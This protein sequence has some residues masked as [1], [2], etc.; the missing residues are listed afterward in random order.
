MVVKTTSPHARFDTG[1]DRAFSY[2][3][4]QLPT[5]LNHVRLGFIRRERH[6]QGWRPVEELKMRITYFD[7]CPLNDPGL[8]RVNRSRQLL[9]LNEP[10]RDG[11]YTSRGDPGESEDHARC[12]L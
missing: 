3:T 9:L 8:Y 6:A 2:S 1:R 7:K 11:S 12:Q 5:R 4:R 10:R